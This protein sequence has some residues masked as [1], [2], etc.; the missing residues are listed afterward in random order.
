MVNVNIF[1]RDPLKHAGT[2]LA[3]ALNKG[4]KEDFGFVQKANFSTTDLASGGLLAPQQ[5]RNLITLLKFPPSLLQE[6]RL[7]AMKG[8]TQRIDRIAFTSRI[9]HKATEATALAAGSYGV[10][11][12]SKLELSSKEFIAVVPLTYS[13]VEDVIEGS[14]GDIYGSRFLDK[15]LGLIVG[16]LAYDLEEIFLLSDTA[17]ATTDYTAF[18]G[19]LKLAQNTNS[20]DHSGAA[21]NKAFFKQTLLTM[22]KPYRRNISALRWFVSPN[23]PIEWADEQADR[24]T[25]TGDSVPWGDREIN[26]AYAIP[27]RSVGSMPEAS[28]ASSNLGKVLISHPKNLIAGIQREMFFEIQ[29]QPSTREVYIY[30]TLRGCPQFEQV[31]GACVG[32]DVKI[33]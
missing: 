26:R 1:P 29:R 30:I 19:W 32:Y 11:T 6:V 15:I 21:V 17:S 22:Q 12:T 20:Y 23:M 14:G 24:A 2:I 28:G 33:A 8:P 25:T 10:P 4:T 7:V 5:S 3:Q 31:E 16:Q 9:L 18:D 27:M 13:A